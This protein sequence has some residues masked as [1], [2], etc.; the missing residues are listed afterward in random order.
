MQ[1]DEH[2]DLIKVVAHDLKSPIGAVKGYID[3]MRHV[4]TLNE[5]QQHFALRALEGLNYMEHLIANLIE[6]ARLGTISQLDFSEC[7][8]Q[9]LT[10]DTLDMLEGQI[11]KRDITLQVKTNSASAMVMGDQRLLGQVMHNLLSNAI[12]YNNDH[13]EIHVAIEREHDFVRVSV[14]DSG[15]GIP[16]EDLP[17]VFEQFFRSPASV[18]HQIEGSG[19]GLAIVKTIIEQ[20]QGHVTVESKIGL[21]SLFTVVLPRHT[22]SGESDEYIR[23]SISKSVDRIEGM[24]ADYAEN[25]SEESD[26]VNDDIQESTQRTERDSRSDDR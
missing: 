23:D 10:R 21:G 4:G 15:I 17:R 8:L 2:Y 20:H 25:A 13:G 11:L 5:R 9:V 6:F 1:A 18:E 7:D 24:G 12:K 3:L 14:R 22:K 19:L 26:S 16:P